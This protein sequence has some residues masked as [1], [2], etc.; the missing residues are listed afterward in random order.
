MSHSTELNAIAKYLF[1]QRNIV[2]PASDLVE[3]NPLQTIDDALAI[4]LEMIALNNHNVTGWKCLTPR[5]NGDLIIAPILDAAV[6]NQS[7][8]PIISHQG[9]ALIEPEIAF[10]VG[11]TFEANQTY[12]QAQIDEQ[13]ASTHMALELI[14]SR[15]SKDYS[16]TFF[17]KLADG[18]SN[19]GIFVGPEINKQQAYQ[20]SQIKV[21]L[22]SNEGELHWDGKHPCELPQTPLYWLVNYLTERGVSLLAGQKII[23]GSYCGVVKV[24]LNQPIRLTYENMGEFDVVFT[25]KHID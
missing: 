21:T 17:E 15:F 12:S 3:F 16:A 18:L 22:T 13:I 8:C 23:T 9:K 19:Q 24:E 14:Q 2:N 5:D 11:Q 1:A 20:A 10:V 4:Q 6:D 7:R 25:E